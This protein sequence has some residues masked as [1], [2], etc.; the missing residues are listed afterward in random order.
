MLYANGVTRQHTE[1]E[2]NANTGPRNAHKHVH[3][4][5]HIH[6]AKTNQKQR[7]SDTLSMHRSS[8]T[9]ARTEVRCPP[10]GKEGKRLKSTATDKKTQLEPRQEAPLPSINH[11]QCLF[12]AVLP[13]TTNHISNNRI[14]E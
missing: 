1:G 10:H 5:T 4:H 2:R 7:I 14:Y 13:K 3:T 8:H 9:D 11:P 12:F 6:I